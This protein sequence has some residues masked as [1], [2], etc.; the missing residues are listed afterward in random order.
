MAALVLVNTFGCMGLF[1]PL[2]EKKS[3]SFYETSNSMIK[4]NFERAIH[5]WISSF[6]TKI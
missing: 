3:P 1:F 2:I 5:V 4:F 6:Q